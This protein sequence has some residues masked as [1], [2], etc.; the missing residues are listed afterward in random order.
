VEEQDGTYARERLSEVAILAG[1]PAALLDEVAA[2]ARTV[3]VRAGDW[4]FREGD[5][6]NGLFVVLSGRLE[7]VA[8]DGASGPAVV[9]REL[10]SGDAVGELALLADSP[11]SASVR[12]RRD[13]VL[14]ELPREGFEELLDG[15]DHFA[16]A[17]TRVLAG[18]LQASRSR[19]S[20]PEALAS[21]IALTATTPD[22][23]VAG[24]AR[25]LT[26]GLGRWGSVALMSPGDDLDRLE[27]D[28]DRVILP[29]GAL[30]ADDDW[31]A[32]CL[33][34]ADRL[35]VIVGDDPPRSLGLSQD[36]EL[37]FTGRRRATVRGWLDATGASAHHFARDPDAVATLARRLAGRSLGLVLSGGGARGF[38]HIGVL[39]E[40]RAA[41]V[42][43]DRVGGCSMGAFIGAQVAMGRSADEIHACCHE[44]FVL[45]NPMGDYT[46][47]L[48]AVIRG[49]RA[50]EMLGRVFGERL[51]EEL[52]G[53]FFSVSA[54]LATSN[55]VVM[56]RGLLWEAVG[57][58]ICL[59]GLAPPGVRGDMLLVDGGVLDNL[60]VE[61]MAQTGEGPVI[62]V[63]V[64]AHEAPTP[65]RAPLA[66]TR[67][68]RA[69]DRLRRA[70]TG[71][72]DPV[73][74]VQ[75]TL[76]RTVLL[77]SV[78]TAAAAERHADLVI[79][80]ETQGVSLTHWKALD[81]LRDVGRRA[82]ATALEQAPP[83][84][85]D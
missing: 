55:L 65:P 26:E 84:L 81:H 45:H 4:I 64:S 39:E 60:P 54:D 32:F 80:P 35:L 3:S 24:L 47:P 37:V 78:D 36:T 56:D 62:A 63:D 8:E 43:I 12:A 11:R 48:V 31:T 38:A 9:L 61:T 25:E 42:P 16:R 83:G 1:L 34:Q 57:A 29:A 66:A 67:A 49:R 77:G 5:S 69:R 33:R 21:T 15:S 7:V 51:V 41:G 6:A 40:L 17:L 70:L 68:G 46:L 76:F 22:Q 50:R 23:D 2:R 72:D 18:Q 59:P 28:H 20:E 58:S 14:V 53:P 30:G 10:G 44:E 73:P 27:R 85:L 19:V 52:D 79:A 74:S 82:A 71:V 75:E 13:S